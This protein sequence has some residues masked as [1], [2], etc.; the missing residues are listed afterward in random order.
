MAKK[1]HFEPAGAK[2]KRRSPDDRRREFVAKTHRFLLGTGIWRRHARSGARLG[3]M[4]PLRYRYFPSKDDLI[5]E[6]YRTVYLEPLDTGWE[7]S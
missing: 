5:R 3:V 7:S 6:V 2:Q 4:Q 1:A